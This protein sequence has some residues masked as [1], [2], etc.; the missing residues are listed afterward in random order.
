MSEPA[1]QPPEPEGEPEP[2]EGEQPAPEPEQE[3]QPQA[4]EG[5][6]AEPG[7]PQGQVASEKEIEAM[8]KSLDAEATRH[9]N[10]VSAIMGEGAQGLRPCP[11]CIPNI[12]GFIP[13][14]EAIPAATLVDHVRQALG[15]PTAANYPPDPY[16]KPCPTCDG[17][18]M[19]RTPS[20]VNGQQALP[21]PDCGSKGWIPEGTKR[22]PLTV[23]QTGVTTSAEGAPALEQPP[24]QD[25]W[26][27]GPEHPD[28]GRLPNY[29]R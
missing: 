8:H 3:P 15:E 9:A 25:P 5:E 6:P 21:C 13:P 1:L 17:W 19:L 20:H 2:E 27:R 18:G 23:V 11:L 28:Y 10:R 26:G 29:V 14:E 16:S 4:P 7:E 12:P 24:A 22:G